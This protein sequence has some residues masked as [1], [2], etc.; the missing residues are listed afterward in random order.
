MIKDKKSAEKINKLMLDMGKALDQS[1]LDIQDVI[2]EEELAQYKQAVAKVMADM[3][4][5]IM[6]PIYAEHPSLKPEE[7]N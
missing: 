2:S 1:I 7:L 4:F 5:D 6:N 3:L